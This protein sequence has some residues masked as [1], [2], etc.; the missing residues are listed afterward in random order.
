V[1]CHESR[2]AA[3]ILVFFGRLI[4]PAGLRLPQFVPAAGDR[5]SRRWIP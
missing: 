3:S 2:P 5:G 1:V 4:P